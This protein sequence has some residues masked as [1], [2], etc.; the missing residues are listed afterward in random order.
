M[1]H[2]G[3]WGTPSGGPRRSGDHQCSIWPVRSAFGWSVLHLRSLKGAVSTEGKHPWCM[4]KSAHL[5]EQ[6]SP[7]FYVMMKALCIQ[8]DY[9]LSL[10]F[11]SAS[12]WRID[13]FTWRI[14]QSVRA[15][16]P[17]FS[18]GGSDVY[19]TFVT[20]RYALNQKRC[21]HPQQPWS[22]PQLRHLYC[23]PWFI[24][25]TG[26]LSVRACI[27][28]TNGAL[29]H[30]FE[31]REGSHSREY[32]YWFEALPLSVVR[33]N[34]FTGRISARRTLSAA[35]RMAAQLTSFRYRFGLRWSLLN[36]RHDRWKVYH[37]TP[38]SVWPYHACAMT[39]LSFPYPVRDRSRSGT[40][41]LFLSGDCLWDSIFFSLGV[42]VLPTR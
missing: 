36:G 37:T 34:V 4:G 32:R 12:C 33:F 29:R 5:W 42:I 1:F 39:N 10:V 20:C 7:R 16:R 23:T 8:C 6:M 24:N 40:V 22:A 27:V 30:C 15:E 3:L 25:A 35:S 26:N 28:S 13:V 19:T 41:P 18:F 31:F 14:F 17:S 11:L 21:V 2:S 9:E 38:G